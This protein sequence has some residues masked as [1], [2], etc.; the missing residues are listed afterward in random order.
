MF[1][2]G[3]QVDVPYFLPCPRQV[4]AYGLGA[5]SGYLG[6]FFALV[7]LHVLHSHDGALERGQ[8]FDDGPYQPC[9][10]LQL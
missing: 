7:F 10:I 6:N 1:L 9:F 5:A 4:A 3:L 8:R 2:Y